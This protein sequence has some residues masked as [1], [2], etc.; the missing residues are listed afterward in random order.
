M[1]CCSQKWLIFELKFLS[2]YI[3]NLCRINGSSY[4]LF[5]VNVHYIGKIKWD[6]RKTVTIVKDGEIVKTR[7]KAQTGEYHIYEGKHEAIIPEE[8]FNAA[9]EK[10]G[11]NDRTPA[12]KKIQNPFA[13]LLFCECGKAMILRFYKKKDGS[14]RCSPRLICNNQTHCNSGSCTFDELIKGVCDILQQN[15][16][17]VKINHYVVINRENSN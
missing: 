5:L 8:L 7:P 15:I 6:W 12:S 11:K 13:S 17:E 9:Q 3:F 2:Y 4:N 10:L 16:I 14:E 1:F